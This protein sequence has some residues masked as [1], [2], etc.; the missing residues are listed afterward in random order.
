MS[1]HDAG[2]EASKQ[3][4]KGYAGRLWQ[5]KQAETIAL[6]INVGRRLGLYP[7]LAGAGPVTA[8]ELASKS[9]YMSTPPSTP[10]P[11]I[12]FRLLVV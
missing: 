7:L 10:T 1:V 5:Y 9:T 2:A 6:M 3:Q 11:F 8:S 12:G 4:D